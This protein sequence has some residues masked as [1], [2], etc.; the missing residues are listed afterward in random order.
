MGG[1]YFVEALQLSSLE[2]IKEGETQIN[3]FKYL[4]LYLML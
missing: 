1:N 3:E 4:G 2:T